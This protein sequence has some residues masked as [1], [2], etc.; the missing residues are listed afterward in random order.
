MHEFRSARAADCELHRAARLTEVV[1]ESLANSLQRNTSQDT[2]DREQTDTLRIIWPRMA[3]NL[4]R[5][6]GRDNDRGR[7]SPDQKHQG[8][9]GQLQ[10]LRRVL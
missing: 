6:V 7:T 8:F 2:A 9:R 5:E 4:C 1:T 3:R 10:P